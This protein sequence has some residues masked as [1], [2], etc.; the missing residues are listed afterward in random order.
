MK[1][2]ELQWYDRSFVIPL[3]VLKSRLIEKRTQNP[4]FSDVA[5]GRDVGVD[6]DSYALLHLLSAEIC[7]V[8]G[9]TSSV[10][11]IST[12]LGVISLDIY[13]GTKAYV[14]PELSPNVELIDHITTLLVTLADIHPEQN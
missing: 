9:I 2:Q 5:R 3:K 11:M 7:R 12:D 13:K 10:L 4:Q 1:A 14:D 6:M 8:R